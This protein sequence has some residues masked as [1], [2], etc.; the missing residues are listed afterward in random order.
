VPAGTLLAVAHTRL[1]L[2][3]TEIEWKGTADAIR[4]EKMKDLMN[5]KISQNT[6]AYK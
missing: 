5:I 4:H 3:S 2:L 6:I 1:E